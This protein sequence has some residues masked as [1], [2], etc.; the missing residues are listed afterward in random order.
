MV[1]GI[2]GPPE[3]S[4][5]SSVTNPP[6]SPLKS[7]SVSVSKYKPGWMAALTSSNNETSHAST[8][9]SKSSK[10]TDTFSNK[11]TSKTKPASMEEIQPSTSNDDIAL[12]SS[13]RKKLNK[14][15]EAIDPIQNDW[16][17]SIV[18]LE[19]KRFEAEDH[20]RSLKSYNLAL[21]NISL[22]RQ[23]GMNGLY[24]T[25]LFLT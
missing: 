16:K 24:F 13:K 2:E 1:E 4:G 17:Q 25:A 6:T 22:E 23:L 9:K 20:K 8:K 14:V 3:P 19:R 5:S 21:Q 10:E 12:P 7:T 18:N 11:S 15:D